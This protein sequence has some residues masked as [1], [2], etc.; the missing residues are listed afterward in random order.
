MTS[1]RA[2]VRVRDVLL[3]AALNAVSAPPA[4]FFYGGQAVIEGVL[5]RGRRHYAVA[6]RTPQGD[7]TV[8]RDALRSRVYTD[9]VWSRPFVRGIAGLYETLHLGMR[10]LQWSAMVQLG[11]EVE[12]SPAAIRAPGKSRSRR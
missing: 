2:R 5:M 9:S 12:I 11:D 6:A 3:T 1:M 7:I 8:L 10:A 4:T